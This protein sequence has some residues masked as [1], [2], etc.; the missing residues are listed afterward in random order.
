MQLNVPPDPETLID[1]RLSSGG[2]LRPR[3]NHRMP[4]LRRFCGL[5][6]LHYVTTSIRQGG[7]APASTLLLL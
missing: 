1:K 7:I 3:W 4:R 2:C 6:H 5:N